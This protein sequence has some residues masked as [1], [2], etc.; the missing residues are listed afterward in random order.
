METLRAWITNC[1]SVGLRKIRSQVLYDYIPVFVHFGS[2][3]WVI[4]EGASHLVNGCKWVIIN[5]SYIF[6]NIWNIPAYIWWNFMGY[7]WDSLGY[8]HTCIYIYICTWIIAHRSDSWNAPRCHGR[9]IT[10]TVFS[11]AVRASPAPGVWRCPLA[12]RR[13]GT[14][15]GLLFFFW[16][17][18][19]EC[20][21][22][23]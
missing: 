1:L 17:I 4:L 3:W 21:Y 19:R 10:F 14:T 15:P 18:T 8:I 23:L 22:S 9:S 5:T 2:F 13:V 7:I 11:F 6:N 12:P 16:E 20:W